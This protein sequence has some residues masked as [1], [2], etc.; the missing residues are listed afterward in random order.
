MAGDAPKLQQARIMLDAWQVGT[1]MIR[2]PDS[3]AYRSQVV[4]I[5]KRGPDTWERR[6]YPYA[7]E[8][9]PLTTADVLELLNDRESFTVIDPHPTEGAIPHDALRMIVDN[10]T[11]GMPEREPR[12][13]A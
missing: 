1:V 10:A 12:I 9:D 6:Q 4:A 11:G 7:A 8:G 5:H 2:M 3:V 13:Q